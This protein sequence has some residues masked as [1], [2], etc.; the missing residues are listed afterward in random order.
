MSVAD[1]NVPPTDK[2]HE[3]NA[4]FAVVTV[5]PELKIVRSVP[6]NNPRLYIK[7]W[8]GKLVILY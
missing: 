1:T 3:F 4:I 7:S 6:V 5:N 2:P 8:R